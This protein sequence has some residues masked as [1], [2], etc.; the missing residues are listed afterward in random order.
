MMKIAAKIIILPSFFKA[1]NSKVFKFFLRIHISWG[2]YQNIYKIHVWIIFFKLIGNNGYFLIIF[3]NSEFRW[4]GEGKERK[5]I[6]L[7]K[8]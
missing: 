7:S 2:V 3:K 5:K 1:L 8:G 6:V 4:G